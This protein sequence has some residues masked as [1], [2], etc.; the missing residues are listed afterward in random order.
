M[1]WFAEHY[2]GEAPT[3]RTR[4]T[5]RC[6]GDLAGVAPALVVTAEYDPLRDEGE[7]YA[8]RLEQAGV[9]VDR[10][11]YDGLVHGFADMTP[12]SAG[13]E[14]AM[15]DVVARTRTLLGR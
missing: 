12:A 10:V 14:A 2:L 5:R 6:C 4:G 8:D 7:A 1:V 9:P 3:S 15:A 13:A 11:R